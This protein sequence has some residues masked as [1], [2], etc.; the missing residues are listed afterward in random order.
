ME[1]E[2]IAAGRGDAKADRGTSGWCSA[3][4]RRNG[5]SWYEYT[6]PSQA[7]AHSIGSRLGSCVSFFA[8]GNTQGWALTARLGAMTQVEPDGRQDI[9]DQHRDFLI[10]RTRIALSVLLGAAVV[11]GAADAVLAP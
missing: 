7:G 8:R 1:G 4:R 3:A 11:Y 10:E 2:T 9:R 6:A 5:C